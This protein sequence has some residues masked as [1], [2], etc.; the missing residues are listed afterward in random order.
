MYENAFH[1]EN[2]AYYRFCIFYKQGWKYY[3]IYFSDDHSRVKLMRENID[4]INASLVQQDNA[5]RQYILTQVGSC[6]PVN[7]DVVWICYIHRTLLV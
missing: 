2:S 7:A 4:Y 5:K 1:L 3:N 6:Y